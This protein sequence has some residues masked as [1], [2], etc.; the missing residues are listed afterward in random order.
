MN[1]DHAKAIRHYCTV[2]GIEIP[3]DVSPALVGCD[4]EGINLR[5]ATR[6]VRIAFAAPVT[7]LRAVR[8]TLVAMAHA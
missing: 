5:L 4:G 7:T 6:I 2:A 3:A 8:A 1:V